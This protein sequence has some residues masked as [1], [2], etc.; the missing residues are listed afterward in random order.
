MS[1]YPQTG[2]G[3]MDKGDLVQLLKGDIAEDED[4][5]DEEYRPSSDE[6]LVINGRL[7]FTRRNDTFPLHGTNRHVHVFN[8]RFIERL[9]KQNLDRLLWTVERVLVST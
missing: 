4:N 2:P 6:E 1:R 8:I 5:D 7:V 3:T 9:S